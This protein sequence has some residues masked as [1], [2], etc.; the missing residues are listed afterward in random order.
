MTVHPSPIRIPL[1]I[2]K[3]KIIML[4]TQPSQYTNC[5]TNSQIFIIVSIIELIR[6][7]EEDA[8]E[9]LRSAFV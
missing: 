2:E 3:S 1:P 9:F 8:V 5:P 7:S 4:P 6:L